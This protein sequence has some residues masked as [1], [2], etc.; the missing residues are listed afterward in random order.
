MICFVD[1]DNITRLGCKARG[2]VVLYV[3]LEAGEGPV[4]SILLTITLEEA[5]AWDKHMNSLSLAGG[6]QMN[7]HRGN[8]SGFSTA[9][10]EHPELP[11]SVD[12]PEGNVGTDG[13]LQLAGGFR[14][15]GQNQRGS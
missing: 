12:E 1:E 3:R 4:V 14:H 9:C 10:G 11:A 7:P 5:S 13:E 15:L 6:K 8:D 2:A